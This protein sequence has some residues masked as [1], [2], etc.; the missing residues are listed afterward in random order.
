MS[1][2]IECLYVEEKDFYAVYKD[3]NI[4]SFLLINPF[5]NNENQILFLR[6]YN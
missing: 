6:L 4:F 3:V 1:A 5:A 2:E